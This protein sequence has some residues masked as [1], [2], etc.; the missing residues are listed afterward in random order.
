M[1]EKVENAKSKTEQAKIM[2]VKVPENDY[3]GNYSSKICGGVGGATVDNSTKEDVG[4]FQEKK[5]DSKVNG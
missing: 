1:E 5:F 3:W 4:T 2:G